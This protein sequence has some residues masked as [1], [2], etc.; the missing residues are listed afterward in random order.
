MA[1]YSIQ[2]E[3]HTKWHASWLTA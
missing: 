1:H 2:N 3:K